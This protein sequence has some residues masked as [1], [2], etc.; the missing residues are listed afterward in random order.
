VDYVQGDGV[1]R[2]WSLDAILAAQSSASLMED[3]ALP[4]LLAAAASGI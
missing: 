3:A 1:A 4:E 2:P